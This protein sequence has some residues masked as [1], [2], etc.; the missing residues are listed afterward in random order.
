MTKLFFEVFPSLQVDSESK[1]LFQEVEVTKITSTSEK[2]FIRVHIFSTHLIPRRKISQ[3]EEDIERQL[4]AGTGIPV[5]LAEEYRLSEQYTPEYL[6]DEYRDSMLFELEGRSALE[7]NIFQ[8]AKCSFQDQ[9]VLC[10]TVADTIVAKEKAE[11][12]T[13]Y[14]K[15]VFERRFHLPIE[16][17]VTY[18]K[19][20]ENKYR[21]M[22]ELQLKQAVDAIQE[23]NGNV[24]A[25]HRPQQRPQQ[26]TQG[27][28]GVKG[29]RP[30]K[31]YSIKKSD[32]PNVI[33]GRDFDDV[34][35]ELK[36]VDSEMGEI[37]LHGQV[38]QFETREIRNEKTILIFAVTDFTDTITVKM[39]V[40]NEQLPE[41]LGEI[42]K[43]AFLK[44]KGVT[45]IDKYDGE[46]TIGSVHGIRKTADFRV[47][48]KDTY[49]EKR[50]ELHCHT[51]MSDMDGV[52]EAKALV[53]RAHDWGHPAIAITD[54]GVVQA[55]PDANHYLETLDKDDPFKVLYGVE[56]YLVDDLTEIVSGA[57]EQTLDDTYVV[58]DIETTGFSAISDKII[59]IGAVKVE[60][61]RIVERFS[62]FVNPKRPIPFRIT[63]LTGITDEMVLDAP[64]IEE[65]LPAFLEFTEGAVLV[66]HNAGFDM[67]FIEQN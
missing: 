23:H 34:P 16:V 24:Q 1:V 6:M 7:K 51:K 48:R 19:I 59:E 20:K 10:M 64:S 27:S 67:R 25:Q 22:N 4:F 12:I 8:K 3:M 61:G 13:S 57:G 53:K 30:G 43:G 36:Q 39:F 35:I 15:L 46:L 44:I 54:H 17:Q 33:Y 49:P 66:A 32:D 42:K 55:F 5:Y 2:K 56:G 21:K 52:S 47:Q 14:L 62:T 40:R 31:S 26:K 11:S 28:G 29:G 9:N 50:V 38:V 18:E 58:F 60:E 37:T 63:N 65:A 45:T 41:L